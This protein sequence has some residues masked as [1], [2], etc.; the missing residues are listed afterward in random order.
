MLLINLK[1]YDYLI[2]ALSNFFFVDILLHNLRQNILQEIEQSLQQIKS[3]E[4][5][6]KINKKLI[7]PIHVS[8]AASKI[9]TVPLKQK[10]KLERGKMKS[11]KRIFDVSL[12]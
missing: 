11:Q 6:H 8:I 12:H 9:E 10:N 1:Y 2:C 5:L 7:A 4:E 3:R